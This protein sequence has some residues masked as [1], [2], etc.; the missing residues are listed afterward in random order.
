MILKPCK[1]TSKCKISAVLLPLL[2]TTIFTFAKNQNQNKR[3]ISYWCCLK[4]Y[5]H[6]VAVFDVWPGHP[7]ISTRCIK[8]WFWFWGRRCNEVFSTDGAGPEES[9]VLHLPLTQR[10]CS[11]NC[12]TPSLPIYKENEAK[13][14]SIFKSDIYYV[15][16]VCYDNQFI[17]VMTYCGGAV[18]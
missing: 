15:D 18:D 13:W 2:L 7:A 3:A 4:R 11:G 17:D 8:V 1:K 5:T 14:N 12:N 10:L 16:C 9:A 6:L